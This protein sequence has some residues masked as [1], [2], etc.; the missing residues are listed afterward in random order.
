M[1][2]HPIQGLMQTAMEN[3]KAMVDVNT[4]VGD[5][6]NTPDGSV[7]LPI[8]KVAFGFAAGG[9]DYNTNVDH[10]GA[11]MGGGADGQHGHQQSLPFGGGS[12][13]GVS[14]RPIAFLVVG[15]EGVHIVPLDNQTHLFERL[16]DATPYLLEQIQSMFQ[17]GN[18]AQDSSQSQ[19]S[20]QSQKSQ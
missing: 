5:P 16:I 15:N 7:I 13:G 9:S 1:S 3:I 12:G 11:R 17:T 4:I 8:S 2:D 6:V 19:Q 10:G 20:Q 14:I 18:N